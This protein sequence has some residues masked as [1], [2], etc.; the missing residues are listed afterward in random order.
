MEEGDAPGE[1]GHITKADPELGDHYSTIRVGPNNEVLPL[2][3]PAIVGEL[4]TDES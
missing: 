4:L 3:F 2:A 1:D